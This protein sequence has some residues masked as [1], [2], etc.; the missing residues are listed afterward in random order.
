MNVN[1]MTIS[2]FSPKTKLSDLSSI[3]TLCAELDDFDTLP[4]V[5][6]FI[7]PSFDQ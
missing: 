5:S 7:Y 6:V 3:G 1:D 4:S 2:F